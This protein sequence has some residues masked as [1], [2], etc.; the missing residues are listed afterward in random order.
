MPA[1]FYGWGEEP[2]YLSHARWRNAHVERGAGQINK[3]NQ[4]D[5]MAVFY[6]DR[7]E[8][9]KH[10][11]VFCDGYDKVY[12]I[13]EHKE[14]PDLA[15][16]RSVNEGELVVRKDSFNDASWDSVKAFIENQKRKQKQTF[17]GNFKKETEDM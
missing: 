5:F 14:Y 1:A 13:I 3:K 17:I 2:R 4:I 8:K 7:I 6:Q 11:V 16:I 9:G 10:G 15:I 12:D